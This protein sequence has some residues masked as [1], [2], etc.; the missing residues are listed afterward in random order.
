[1]KVLSLLVRDLSISSIPAIG[2]PDLQLNDVAV[3]LL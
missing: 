3:P 2:R 1:M